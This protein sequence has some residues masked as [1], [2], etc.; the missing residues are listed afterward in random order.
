MG[1]KLFRLRCLHGLVLPEI[2]VV[3]TAAI[4]QIRSRRT[5]TRCLGARIRSLAL[6]NERKTEG[7]KLWYPRAGQETISGGRN[8]SGRCK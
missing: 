7:L 2:P 4:E 8:V 1:R 3:D 5:R 6:S